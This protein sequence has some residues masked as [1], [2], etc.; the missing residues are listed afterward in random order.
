[1]QKP[2]TQTREPSQM[3]PLQQSWPVPPQSRQRSIG[4]HTR[5]AGQTLPA[6]Q[7]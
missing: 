2:A 3:L 4:S 6:Q 7:S 5:P 1:M